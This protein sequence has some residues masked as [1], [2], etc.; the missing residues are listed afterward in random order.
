MRNVQAYGS[1]VTRTTSFMTFSTKH[2]SSSVLKLQQM[3]CEAVMDL[4]SEGFK[5]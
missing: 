3:S 5:F 2:I 1:Y 4:G